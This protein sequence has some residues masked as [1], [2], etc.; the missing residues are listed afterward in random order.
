MLKGWVR[1]RRKIMNVWNTGPRVLLNENCSERGRF[2]AARIPVVAQCSELRVEKQTWHSGAFF[3]LISVISRFFHET[4]LE[5]FWKT[6][7]N[8]FNLVSELKSSSVFC[9]AFHTL[10]NQFLAGQ[11]TTKNNEIFKLNLTNKEKGHEKPP[12]RV[13]FIAIDTSRSY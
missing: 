10:F 6:C 5:N 7:N 8:W 4:V 13:F 1:V 9:N 11:I 2:K 3:F 12:F